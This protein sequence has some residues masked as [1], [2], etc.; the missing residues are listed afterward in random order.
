M[1]SQMW[2][3]K[4]EGS[5]K[6]RRKLNSIQFSFIYIALNYNNCHLNDNQNVIY[7]NDV[8]DFCSLRQLL[9]QQHTDTQQRLKR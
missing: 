1:Q 6:E 2:S 7:Y 3:Q 4:A 9:P 5:Q 8:D